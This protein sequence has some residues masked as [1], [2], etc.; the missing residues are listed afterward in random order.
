MELAKQREGHLVAMAFA[1]SGPVDNDMLVYP[2]VE[3]NR[4]FPCGLYT[5]PKASHIVSMKFLSDD[6][7]SAA[8]GTDP[9][10]FPAQMSDNLVMRLPPF[11]I[12]T[13]EFDQFRRGNEQFGRRLAQH[14]KLLEFWVQAGCGHCLDDATAGTEAV[15]LENLKLVIR[16]LLPPD[17]A[18]FTQVGADAEQL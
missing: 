9:A 15:R 4:Q 8:F 17:Q 14:Q 6:P 11:V 16:H 5:S 18:L 12:F 2:E 1:D 13:R 10:I 7:E 3:S